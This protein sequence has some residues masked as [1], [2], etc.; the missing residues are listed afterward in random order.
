MIMDVMHLSML[1]P[2][3][4]C[5]CVCG[6]GPQAY[7]GHLTSI[8]FPILVNLIRNLGPRVGTSAFSVRRNRTK[9]HHPVCLSVCTAAIKALKDGFF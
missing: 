9:S 6:G 4:V 5:V 2:R 1:S 7:V 8:A 3:G